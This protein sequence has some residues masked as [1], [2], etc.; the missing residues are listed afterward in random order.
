MVSQFQYRAVHRTILAVDIQNFGDLR[1]NNPNQIALRE[2]M[3]RSLAPSGTDSRGGGT[4]GPGGP[5]WRR[6]SGG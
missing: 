3:Y 2:G 5:G 4:G 6:A 1:R